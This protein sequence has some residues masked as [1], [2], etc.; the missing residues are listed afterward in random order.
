M[1]FPR[2]RASLAIAVVIYRSDG[3]DFPRDACMTFGYRRNPTA[4]CAL[5]V[6]SSITYPTVGSGRAQLIAVVQEIRA[7]FV[8]EVRFCIEIIRQEVGVGGAGHRQTNWPA[9]NQIGR[10]RHNLILDS[11]GG[12]IRIGQSQELDA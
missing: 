10:A 1:D 11:R 12:N 7:V 8:P 9:L 3:N 4:C 2:F 6:D 5:R